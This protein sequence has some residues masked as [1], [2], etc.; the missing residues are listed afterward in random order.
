MKSYEIFYWTVIALIGIEV[1][2]AGIVGLYVLLKKKP[3]NDLVKII[4]QG[5]WCISLLSFVIAQSL[6]SIN[7]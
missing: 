6:V 7:T 2:I 4:A 3:L 1:I 5:I